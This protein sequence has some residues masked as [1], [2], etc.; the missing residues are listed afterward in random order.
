MVKNVK[1]FILQFQL[2]NV[3]LKNTYMYRCG[4]LDIASQ[5]MLNMRKHFIPVNGH[6]IGCNPVFHSQTQFIQSKCQLINN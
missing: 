5:Q 3:I 4:P 6:S 2:N 1:E